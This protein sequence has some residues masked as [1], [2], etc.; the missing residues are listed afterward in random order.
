MIMHKSKQ[1]GLWLLRGLGVLVLVGLILYMADVFSGGKIEPGK[2]APPPS[3]PAPANTDTTRVLSVPVWYEAVGTVRSRVEAKVSPQVT[4]RVTSVRVEEGTLVREGDLICTLA[5]DEFSARLEQAR[6]GVEAARA[7]QEQSTLN[8]ARMRRLFDQ[9]AATREQLEAADALKKQADAGLEAAQQKLEE[10][11]VALGYTRITS[12]LTG[13][14]ARREVD[15]GDLAWPGKTLVVVHDAQN[16]R[17][18]ASVREGL[19]SGVRSGQEVEVSITALGRSV[20]A[21]VE[22]IVPSA[23]PIS[24]SFVVK[25][26]LPR[27]EGLYPG[28]FGKLRLRVGER[29][30]ITVRSG[31]VTSVGQLS[32]VLLR[33]GDRWVRRY[34]TTGETRDGVTEILSGLAADQTVGLERTGG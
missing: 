2:E 21:P 8:H 11:K 4:G 6:S 20:E 15:P 27:I 22:E 33:Q 25:A 12:P 31:A 10:A 1:V 3:L 18:E 9:Q 7:M 14:L 16:L 34:V 24:R 30:A 32:T 19:I 28:M 13:V 26:K 29:Q 17:L 5:N 23:D